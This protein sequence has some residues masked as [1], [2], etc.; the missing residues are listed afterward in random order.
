MSPRSG[1]GLWTRYLSL[2]ALPEWDETPASGRG[3]HWFEQSYLVLFWQR[4]R[5]HFLAVVVV[6]ALVLAVRWEGPTLHP[7]D[8]WRV[9][10]PLLVAG[11]ALG[12]FVEACLQIRRR[13][14]KPLLSL[15]L[16]TAAIAVAFALLQLPVQALVA[17]FL[18]SALTA[19]ILMPTGQAVGMWGYTGLL[20]ALLIA[21]PLPPV[22]PGPPLTEDHLNAAMWLTT[23]LF[24]LLCLAETLLL[25]RATRRH[26]Q[27][28]LAHLADQTRRDDEFLAGV[29]HA[30]RTPLTCVV[31]F[32][33]L[34]ESDW[35][36]TLPAEV[37]EMLAELNQQADEMRGIVDNLVFRA[38]D[39]AGRL[40]LA[41]E[42]TDL[43]QIASEV[44][45]SVAWLY[46]KRTIRL[47]GD[48]QVVASA[49]HTRTRQVVRNLLSNAIQHGGDLIVLETRDGA[50][51][52]LTVTDNGYDPVPTE[53]SLPPQPWEKGPPTAAS[54]SLN[55]GVPVS[56]RLAELMGGNLTHQ[57]TPGNV[58]F[59]LSLPPYPKQPQ[60]QG[61]ALAPASTE[62]PW[63]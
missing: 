48:P 37:G 2:W 9:G 59:T 35:G 58:T 23:G 16:D 28:H 19:A 4:L 49:D 33:Q 21:G 3:A 5:A 50:E 46:P 6:S 27:A 31:G 42:P 47:A 41:A 25:T 39:A 7:L 11:L 56:L 61:P 36:H 13:N 38:K 60:Q 40:T 52:T 62:P 18:Y 20:A 55:F 51:A 22:V 63:V 34:I 12:L 43:R 53:G 32:G 15:L 17:P 8:H 44:I 57:Q 10:A 30:L 29:S 45:R 14:T 26:T 1:G 54:P 24:G